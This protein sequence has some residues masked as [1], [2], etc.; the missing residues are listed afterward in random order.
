MQ[1]S[2][3]TQLNYIHDVWEPH[4]NG[5]KAEVYIACWKVKRSKLDIK[6]V[7]GKVNDTSDFAG[8]WFI[9]RKKVMRCKIFNNN[10]LDCFVVP[11]KYAE[12]LITTHKL[13]YEEIW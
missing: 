7:F 13:A 3:F 6:L 11:W 10:G 1:V 8:V 9:P 4:Y 12:P 5:G 2:K